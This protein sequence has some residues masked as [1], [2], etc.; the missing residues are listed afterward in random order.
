[1][2]K[3]QA[4]VNETKQPEFYQNKFYI[5]SLRKELRKK[6]KK[7]AAIHYYIVPDESVLL[8]AVINFC[9]MVLILALNSTVDHIIRQKLP[10]QSNLLAL[11]GALHLFLE[12]PNFIYSWSWSWYYTKHC[13]DNSFQVREIEGIQLLLDC[14]SADGHNPFITQ[15]VILAI[16]NLCFGNKENQVL[17]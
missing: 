4:I 16:R 6:S 10:I 7:L 5:K 12:L 15:W 11:L 8:V 17:Q 2:N 3:K 13:V 1:M 14:S 9:Q